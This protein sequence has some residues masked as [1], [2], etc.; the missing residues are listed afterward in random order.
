MNRD[1]KFRAKDI[2]TKQWVYGSYFEHHKVNLFFFETDYTKEEADKIIKDNIRYLMVSTI[3][4]DFNMEN[5][6]VIIDVDPLTVGQFI[7]RQDS[8]K[9]D[10]YMGDIIVCPELNNRSVI[11]DSFKVLSIIDNFVENNYKF[12]KSGTIFDKD[13]L[14]G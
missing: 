5:R 13:G 9:I 1:I 3:S 8:N 6:L 10:L 11:I 7:E 12:Y 2:D 4:G 14:D